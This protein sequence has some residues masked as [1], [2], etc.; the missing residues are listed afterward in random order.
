MATPNTADIKNIDTPRKR[1]LYPL[2]AAIT[3]IT[4]VGAVIY[5]KYP[6]TLS[7]IPLGPHMASQQ[8]TS[9]VE[10]PQLLINFNDQDGMKILRFSAQLEVTKTGKSNVITM[11]PRIVDAMNGYLRGLDAEVME[12][13]GTLFQIRHDLLIRI[14]V[15]AGEEIIKKFLIKEFII[16]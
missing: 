9:F 5:L 15:V 16:Q 6:N 7:M 12:E 2:M 13:P 10:L 8:E 1:R 11:I 4:I 14:Q 3:L